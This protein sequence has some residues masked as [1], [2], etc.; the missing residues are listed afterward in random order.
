MCI[1][2]LILPFSWLLTRL[3]NYFFPTYKT[4]KFQ[5]QRGGRR[6]FKHTRINTNENLD[7]DYDPYA[8]W[9]IWPFIDGLRN[10]WLFK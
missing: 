1:C 5:G 10:N 8:N 7:D 9:G 2:V 6:K 4:N 3:F